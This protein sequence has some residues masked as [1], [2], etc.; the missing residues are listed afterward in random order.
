MAVHDVLDDGEPEPGAAG[1][2]RPASDPPGRSARSGG[3]CARRGMPGPSSLTASS[4]PGRAGSRPTLQRADGSR[5]RRLPGHAAPHSPA[6]CAP[7]GRAA[8]HP[9]APPP[10]PPR[11]GAAASR[12]G[13]GTAAPA[14]PPRPGRSPPAAA[15][16]TGGWCSVSSMRD[17]P[18][19]SS[20]SRRIALGLLGHDRRGSAC[21]PPHHPRPGRAGSR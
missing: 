12:R 11:G 19:R 1:V 17:R 5:T 8:R 9:P 2:A 10:P 18:S 14:P 4:T 20:I 3:E 7:P 13:R 6:G 21:A 15:V 16:P